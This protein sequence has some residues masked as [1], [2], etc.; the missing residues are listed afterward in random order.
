MKKLHITLLFSLAVLIASSQK[1]YF[2]YIQTES[3]QP[4]FV[5]INE[6]V[7]S[8]T[9]SG[10]IILPKLLDSTYSFSIGFPQNKWPEQNFSVSVNKKDHGYLLKNFS[11]KG[12]GLFDLQTLNVQMAITGKA[13]ISEKPNVENKDISVFTEIL[14]R[15]ADDPSLKEK[16]LQPK[17]EEKKTEVA[18]QEIEK[19]EQIKV[20]VKETVVV[21]SNE[22]VE[23]PVVKTQEP[24]VEK[25]STTIIPKAIIE[26]S[27]VKTEE[28]KTEVKE[29]VLI[30][31]PEI[32][33]QSEVKKEE[34]KAVIR[35]EPASEAKE[36]VEI[37][38]EVYK[39]SQVK[40]WSESSTT[41]GF[42]LVFTDD[43]ENGT[44]DTIRLLIPNPKP[45]VNLV[46]EQP[47]EEKKFLDISIET[48]KKEEEK[49]AE[50][51][52]VISK[53]LVEK[54]VQK[55]NCSEIATSSDFFKLR[56]KMAVAEKDDDMISEAK[57][58]FKTKC[59]TLLQVKNLSTL[60][61][62]D[63]GKYKF[64]DAS[65]KYVSDSEAFG[66]LEGEMKDEYYTSRFKAMLRN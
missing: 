51:E 20:D 21:K 38:T 35:E 57:K 32:V 44:R 39:T 46:K 22:V 29:P 49:T 28:S 4:F 33:E 65:Y 53:K 37:V 48:P 61:L 58:Y 13:S 10:Y 7:N 52:R 19:K 6:K 31:P 14:S 11:D 12:W 63:E 2:I 59:F 56:K 3:E 26:Q 24:K 16:P 17:L 40:K 55:N 54:T 23:A 42:G 5:K 36:L 41:E 18:I 34:S 15:A 50:I 60:F 62:N 9:A 45:V 25:E 8:S 27:V 30:K 43:Y 66:S 1:V 64:F 47:K